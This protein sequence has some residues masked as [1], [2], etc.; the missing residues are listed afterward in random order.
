MKRRIP[1]TTIERPSIHIGG[2]VVGYEVFSQKVVSK[3]NAP[4]T[5]NQP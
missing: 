2:A 4:F 3:A 5:E 1:K